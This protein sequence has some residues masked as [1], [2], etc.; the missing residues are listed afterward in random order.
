MLVGVLIISIW[1]LSF[2]ILTSPCKTIKTNVIMSKLS[3]VSG[4]SQPTTPR[5]FILKQNKQKLDV[6]PAFLAFILLRFAQQLTT[7]IFT[8]HRKNKC[9]LDFKFQLCLHKNVSG[10]EQSDKVYLKVKWSPFNEMSSCMLCCI[11]GYSCNAWT[12][13]PVVINKLHFTL[14]V[15]VAV[16]M[17]SWKGKMKNKYMYT[18]T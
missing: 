18:H 10:A 4:R 16:I 17:Q 8:T 1:S 9:C 13:W 14:N 5:G 15:F 12:Q 2:S 6:K 7:K 11:C 3:K